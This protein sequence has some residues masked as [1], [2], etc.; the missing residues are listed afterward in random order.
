MV[1]KGDG[2]K[3]GDLLVSG[4]V[5]DEKDKPLYYHSQA[6]IIGEYTERI[7]ITQSYNDIKII[8]SHKTIKRNYIN[9]F[10]IKIPINF[11][12]K[13]QG[14]YS[15]SSRT[16]Y[17]SF[18]SMKLPIGITYKKYTP[19]ETKKITYT[20][21]EAKNLLNEKIDIYEVNFLNKCE[22]IDKDI[23]YEVNDKC[24]KVE[25]TYKI[26]GNIAEE[27]KILIKE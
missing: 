1:L 5:I 6:K 8:P 9:F 24:I 16:N 18:L 23:K 7:C 4:I 15:E 27:S 10:D 12:K 19:Y 21:N 22:I 26:R 2:V 25:V 11:N 20:K 13:I 17:I 3:K 14:E